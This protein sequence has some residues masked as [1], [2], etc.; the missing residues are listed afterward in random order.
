MG[1]PSNLV[2]PSVPALIGEVHLWWVHLPGQSTPEYLALLDSAERERAGRL[3][4]A[5]AYRGFVV[6]RGVLRALLAGYL[7]TTTS[8]VVLRYG[9]YGKPELVGGN[10]LTFNVS[11]ARERA[12]LAFRLDGQVGVDVEE[13]RPT[14]GAAQIAER[15]FAPAEVAALR[16]LPPSLWAA[17]FFR[18]WTR[19]E[20][21]VKAV[22]AGLSHDFRS[23]AV[24][25]E[26]SS[27]A[28]PLVAAGGCWYLSDVEAG[29]SHAAA[30][31]V[32][33][34]PVAPAT[35]TEVVPPHVRVFDWTD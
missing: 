28:E 7:G 10:G 30:V 32:A 2:I 13:L 26:P 29:Q 34:E 14:L 15:F 33:T 1:N 17:G 16:A 3:R 19:K 5:E 9:S 8:E 22:G 20:A 31:A 25:V 27:R 24:S 35:V 11:H 12:L 6:T 18:C 4:T 21:F 23:F